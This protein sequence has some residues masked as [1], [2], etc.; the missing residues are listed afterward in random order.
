MSNHGLLRCVFNTSPSVY[1]P[2]M[3]VNETK[4]NFEKDYGYRANT[5]KAEELVI[6]SGT[7]N[8]VFIPILESFTSSF[9][10]T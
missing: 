6:R 3:M 1:S 7:V 2:E 9:K 8:S 10:S 4:E 5:H